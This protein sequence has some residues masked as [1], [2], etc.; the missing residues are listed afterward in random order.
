MMN[1]INNFALTTENEHLSLMQYRDAD[2]IER[3]FE[4]SE[5]ICWLSGLAN[6]LDK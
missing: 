1:P 2:K 6:L 3:R 5:S 4:F